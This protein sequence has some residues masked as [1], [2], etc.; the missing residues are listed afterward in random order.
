MNLKNI[1]SLLFTTKKSNN[2]QFT[3][4]VSTQPNG[5]E[6]KGSKIYWDERYKNGGTSGA[7]SY[8]R[9]AEFKAEILNQFVKDNNVNKV[10]EWGCGDGN[11]LL[12]A[13]YPNYVGF[14]ISPKAIEICQTIFQKDTT[15]QF[16][17]CNS[18]CFK[19]DIKGDLSIS[20][21]VIYHLIEDE[22]YYQYMENLFNSSSKYVCIYSCNDNQLHPCAH[23]K[24]RIFTDYIHQNFSNW[25]LLQF[26][27]NRYPYCPNDDNTSWSDFYFFEL[28][29]K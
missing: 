28:I 13:N 24:H 7:G 3:V 9:L 25:K 29:N 12:Y 6:W 14:D 15:K 27:K 20:L 11:Q 19:T 10:I 17:C 26:I 18:N 4:T 23:I 2:G 8:N 1:I 22:I 16:T 5:F 21:D